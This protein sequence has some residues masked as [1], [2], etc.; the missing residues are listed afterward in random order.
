M[1]PTK[2]FVLGGVGLAT[3]SVSDLEGVGIT[4]PFDISETKLYFEFGGGVE[5]KMGPTMN[6]FLMG[7]YVNVTSEGEAT[8]FIPISVGLKF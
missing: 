5:F 1:A 8:A 4:I 2:P 7:R 6:L 3:L